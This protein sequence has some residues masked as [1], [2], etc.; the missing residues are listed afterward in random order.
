MDANNCFSLRVLS[1]RGQ[2]DQAD[3]NMSQ[4]TT[5]RLVAHLEEGVVPL[6]AAEVSGQ[7]WETEVPI[8][9]H[10][11]TLLLRLTDTRPIQ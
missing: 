4:F 8:Y 9:A 6:H 7:H 1:A 10:P 5:D 11:L 2:G 3:V